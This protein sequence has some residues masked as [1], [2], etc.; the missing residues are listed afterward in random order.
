[1]KAN[2]YKIE[3]LT[4]MHVGSGEAN[5]GIIDNLVQRDATTTLPTINGSSLK[6]ALKEFFEVKWGEKDVKLTHIFGSNDNNAAYRFLS[7]NLIA[8][9][10]RSNKKAWFLATAPMVFNNLIKEAGLFHLEIDPLAFNDF[11]NVAQGTPIV[12]VNDATGLLV[13]DFERFQR[14]DK[15]ALQTIFGDWENLIILNDEDFISLCSDDN[16]PVIARNKVNENKN[17]WYEQVVPHK[18][19]FSF[20]VF[21]NDKNKTD[22]DTELEESIVH[23]GAN[24]TVGNGFTKITK[25]V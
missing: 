12:F 15:P 20:V 3:A 2:F 13:E 10:V 9:P 23:I 21:H 11:M 16:L 6:G 22:F 25:I 14:V 4:N 24:A 19:L 17:L 5:F 7:A 1:M 8:I 18:S